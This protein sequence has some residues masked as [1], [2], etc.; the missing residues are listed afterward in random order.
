MYPNKSVPLGEGL[1]RPSIVTLKPTVLGLTKQSLMEITNRISADF[2]DFNQDQGLWTFRV[3][4]WSKYG[5]DDDE[6]NIC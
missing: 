3:M 1:N 4:H 2:V 5:I 6:V